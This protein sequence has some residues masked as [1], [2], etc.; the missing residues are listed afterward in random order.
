MLNAV[1]V[2]EVEMVVL[3]EF[4]LLKPLGDTGNSI[5][6]AGE[7]FEF[8]GVGTD[9]EALAEADAFGLGIIPKLNTPSDHT[10]FPRLS[11]V[12]LKSIPFSSRGDT[13]H[14]STGASAGFERSAGGANMEED[15][16]MLDTED[17][18]V[19][20]TVDLASLPLVESAVFPLVI[21]DIW[22]ADVK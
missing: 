12:N 15:I 9:K 3:S 6:S 18:G 16:L 21:M 10:A 2:V 1:S 14:F 20:G 13:G 7:S 8:S 11:T 19:K 17:G 5:S 4:T 22:S